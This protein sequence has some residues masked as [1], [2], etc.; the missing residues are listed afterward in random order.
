MCNI[1]KVL[2]LI[3]LQTFL[4]RLFSKELLIFFGMFLIVG[5]MIFRLMILIYSV[6]IAIYHHDCRT[7]D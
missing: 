5:E 2:L 4:L 7:F 6:I 3:T 1:W